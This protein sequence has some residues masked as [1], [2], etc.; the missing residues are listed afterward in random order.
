MGLAG[1]IGNI[2]LPYCCS[3]NSGRVGASPLPGVVDE[4]GSTPRNSGVGLGLCNATLLSFGTL[5]T[6]PTVTLP[7]LKVQDLPG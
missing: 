3:D 5:D 7:T 1:K 4:E 2:K 6:V